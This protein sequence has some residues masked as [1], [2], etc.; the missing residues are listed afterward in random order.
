MSLALDAFGLPAVIVDRGGRLLSHNAL[1]AALTGHTDAALS[2]AKLPLA[3]VHLPSGEMVD[4]F[5]HL[6][7][8]PLP[9]RGEAILTRPDGATLDV[10]YTGG[11]GD[12]VIVVTLIDATDE[13]CHACK[14]KVSRD[15]Y[16]EAFDEQTEMVCRFLPDSTVTFVN[17]AYAQALG[18]QPRE[19]IGVRL[20]DLMVPAD[21][22]RFL[23]HLASFTNVE[24][25]KDGEESFE[26][27]SGRVAHHWWRRRA[28]FGRDNRLM[29]FQ[30]VGRDVTERRE[31]EMRLRQ[32]LAEQRL[33]FEHASFGIGI[34]KD[35]RFQQVNRALEEIFGFGRDEMIG[36]TTEM[37]YPSRED[38]L[39]VGLT[40]YPALQRG[41]SW[42][43]ERRMRRKDGSLL[44]AYIVGSAIDP[45]DLG[46]GT[47]WLL[48]DITERK[49]ATEAMRLRDRAIEASS[50]GIII[51]CARTPDYP[52]IY[53][54]PA[55][56]RLTGFEAAQVL[57]RNCRFLQ[58]DG[59]DDSGELAKIRDGL[60]A[61]R[62]VR[63]IL[64]NW[65]RDG[66]M[67]WN[68]LH[69][70][71]VHDEAGQATHF[72]GIQR[73]VTELIDGQESLRRAKET[74]EVAN[75]SKSEFLANMSHELRTPL[76]AILG[77]SEAIA[78]GIFG[79]MGNDRYLEYVD[80][81]HQSGQHLLE[82]ITD[83]LD[84]SAIEAGKLELHDEPVTLAEVAESSLRLVRARAE[85]GRVKLTSAVDLSLPL[86]TADRRRV[87]Q[88]LVNLLSNAV[89]FTPPDGSVILAARREPD[90][91]LSLTVTDT[92]IGMD[93]I[94]LQIALTPFGQVESAF[95][96]SNEGTGLGLPLTIGLAELHGAKLSITSRKGEGTT[97]TVR[98]P[99]AR[100]L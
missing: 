68:E 9:A 56:E 88:I 16:R 59:C 29:A 32:A 81:I 23:G 39:E 44:W 42:R 62:P 2:G 55:F 85:K 31:A 96:R 90:G 26:L 10:S 75:R 47:V 17:E 35:R 73:D 98:F 66:T 28:V 46:R 36:Q 19:L 69:L 11:Q 77:Y 65:R 57:G 94:G 21:R 41:E 83:I 79:P 86:L 50:N 93:E 52:I 87:T 27:P 20:A 91:D 80:C 43:T 5:E 84:V 76:N 7:R 6:W 45:D 99:A 82:L 70:A 53:V 40:C 95:A 60:A 15:K 22:T 100:V 54:N 18:R 34:L 97:V 33:V 8:A 92:G 64:R 78:A 12:G 63:A 1:F 58:R 67:F 25:M 72:I 24:A 48:E 4:L 49:S 13:K 38:Y 14:I 71:P 89:K 74:A 3:H 61:R 37:L 51:S 30:S